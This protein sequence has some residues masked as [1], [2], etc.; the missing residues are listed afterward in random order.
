MN[1]F[2]QIRRRL[3]K[4]NW[5]QLPLSSCVFLLVQGSVNGTWFRQV[6]CGEVANCTVI[7][8]FVYLQ[9][10]KLFK[11]QQIPLPFFIFSLLWLWSHYCQFSYPCFYY[12]TNTSSIFSFFHFSLTLVSLL[13]ILL[14]LTFLLCWYYFIAL[15]KT[16][17]N[18]TFPLYY[19]LR[20]I[21]CVRPQNDKSEGHFLMNGE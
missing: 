4:R 5:S 18:I 13:Q 10:Y 16:S 17:K 2:E 9:G 20:I 1:N 3:L 14:L 15:F 12:S 19:V 7:V 11:F 8:L 6:Y 21:A